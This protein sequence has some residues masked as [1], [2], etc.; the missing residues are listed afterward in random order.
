MRQTVR[1]GST[2]LRFIMDERDTMMGYR[3]AQT[4]NVPSNL[5]KGS[6]SGS[7]SAMI[8]GNFNDLLIGQW[9]GTDVLVDPYQGSNSGTFGLL[10]SK[11]SMWQCV[12]LNLSAQRKTTRLHKFD[13]EGGKFFP[14]RPFLGGCYG[15]AP[16]IK[17]QKR[18]LS[19]AR[20]SNSRSEFYG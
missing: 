13:L 19:E 16:I 10:Y 18:V 11:M 15:K 6:T 12:T 7:C 2:D 8:F 20:I 9:G 5:T 3:I 4:S 14:R 1:V 17:K